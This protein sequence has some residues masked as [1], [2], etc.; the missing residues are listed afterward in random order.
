MDDIIPFLIVILITVI[1]S[2][3]QIKKKRAL[4]QNSTQAPQAKRNDDIFGWLEKLNEPELD[5]P[6]PFMQN[7]I[8]PQ[9]EMPVEE[10][11]L[12]EEAEPV[13]EIADN[14]YNQYNGFISPEEKKQLMEMEG[15]S[16][17]QKSEKEEKHRPVTLKKVHP[18]NQKLNEEFDLRKAIVYSE[19]LKRKYQ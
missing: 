8:N 4:Q 7:F 19:I 15:S 1:G 17:L 11:E 9:N 3:S 16:A 10:T 13:I 2:I 14:K 18:W 6:S 12:I 5:R